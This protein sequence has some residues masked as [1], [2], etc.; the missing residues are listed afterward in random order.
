[1]EQI[2]KSSREISLC[3]VCMCPRSHS[4]NFYLILTKRDSKASG[5]LIERTLSVGP[6]WNKAFPYFEF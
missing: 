6:K 2:I 1:M 4:R 5:T 3:D